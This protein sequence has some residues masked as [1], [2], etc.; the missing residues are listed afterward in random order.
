MRMRQSLNDWELAFENEMAL[1]RQRRAQLRQR[2]VQRSRARRVTR[3]EKSG[4]VRFSVLFSAL[5]ATVVV[6]TVV[7]FETLALLM[8]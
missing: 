2:A 8:G 6:V 7:M 5:G 3:T 4:K 1:D